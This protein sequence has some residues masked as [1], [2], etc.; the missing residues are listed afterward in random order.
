M[1][2]F[3]L[4]SADVRVVYAVGNFLMANRCTKLRKNIYIEFSQHGGRAEFPMNIRA[5]TFNKNH[6]E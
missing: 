4:T 1:L 6:I 3:Q 5:S 2:S